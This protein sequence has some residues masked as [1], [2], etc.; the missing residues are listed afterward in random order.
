MTKKQLPIV[1][2]KLD[3]IV[4]GGQTL[5]A[6]DYGKKLFAWGGLPGETVNVQVTKKK[7]NFLEGVVTEVITPS[8]Q[9][10]EPR[11]EDSYLSTSPWQI[12]TFDAEQHY[13]SALIEEAFELHDIVLPQPI[14]IYSDNREFEYRNKIEYSF[15]WDKEVGQLDLAF[16]RR[17]TH[18]K[19][20]VDKTSLA[21]P[22]INTAAHA[23]RDTLRNRETQAF[24]LKTVIVRCDQQGNVA[25]QLYV[26]DEMFDAFT[27]QE[28]K[29]FQIAGFELIFSNP[30]SPA[31]VITKRLQAWGETTLTDSILDVP[32]TYAVEGFFQINIPVYEKALLDMKEWVDSSKPTV[33]L[34]SGVGSIGLTIGGDNVTMVEINEHAVREMERNITAMDR[35]KTAKAILAPSETALEHITSDSTI[36]L[37]PPRAGL[38]E[39]V[40]TKL[41]E[42]APERIIYLSCNPVTQ[43]RDVA[44]LA[45][46]YGIR[47]HQGYNFFPRTPHIEH[48]IVLDKKA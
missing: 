28:L 10:V 5:G 33:D 30:K 6:L 38:H 20:P 36:I 9:R 12:M 32:F 31:S 47:H 7:S 18:G 13:K 41:L 42:A 19:I 43:A 23:I 1:E 14:G 35:A 37:D 39:D 40:V 46:K 48:L 8:E 21:H 45:E 25:A 29:D 16:F 4:G 27:E 24:N 26:K 3:K 2:V 17:G 15:W 22:A 34:Y 44:R 11:D